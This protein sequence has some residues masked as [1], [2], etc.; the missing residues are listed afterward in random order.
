MQFGNLRCY[1]R[2][3]TH[4]S[5]LCIS[6]KKKKGGGVG[7]GALSGNSRAPTGDPQQTELRD[8][9]R[10]RS[11]TD[12]PMNTG[13]S[14]GALNIGQTRVVAGAPELILYFFFQRPQSGA[15]ALSANFRASPH[16]TPPSPVTSHTWINA[17][18]R[19][20]GQVGEEGDESRYPR[21]LH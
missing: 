15:R 5:T 4:P 14:R 19:S 2:K 1:A 10:L 17:G 8:A 16:G 18:R 11:L 3:S 21:E 12:R 7:G 13:E 20:A 9:A 6:Q